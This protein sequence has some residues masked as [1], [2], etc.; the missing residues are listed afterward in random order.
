MECERNDIFFNSNGIDVHHKIPLM[1]IVCEW[2]LL[3]NSERKE[4]LFKSSIYIEC[5]A[6]NFNR[7]SMI[8]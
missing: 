1:W 6:R 4:Q 5:L 7:Y 2:P 3:R 8:D